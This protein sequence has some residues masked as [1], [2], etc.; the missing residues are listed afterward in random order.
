MNIRIYVKNSNEKNHELSLELGGG[1][2]Y[3]RIS[4]RVQD[5]KAHPTM[6]TSVIYNSYLPTFNN[7]NVRAFLN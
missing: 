4:K 7:L 1:F 3:I 6:P 2:P 5:T